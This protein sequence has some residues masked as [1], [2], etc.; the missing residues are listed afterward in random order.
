[1]YSDRNDAFSQEDERNMA[2]LD[3]KII[4]KFMKIKNSCLGI[5]DGDHYLIFKNGTTSGQYICNKLGINYLGERMAYVGLILEAKMNNV[6]HHIKYVI[7]ARHGRGASRTNGA[8]IMSLEKQN[9][10]FI[11]DLFLGGH[12][13]KENCHPI[14]MLYPS[15]N[16]DFVKQK[17][18]WFIRGGSF[19]RGYIPGKVT[20]PELAEYNPLCTGWA[21]IT[22]R[23]GRSK[24]TSWSPDI[25][26]SAATIR[27]A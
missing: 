7:L 12:S 13:H 24:K 3:A 9:S 8:D 1:M 6:I 15:K 25:I 22:L 2:W 23:F 26:E 21:E 27:A 14:P 19:L 4:P 11:A 10:G 18:I 5:L 17:I 20:Y 16:F